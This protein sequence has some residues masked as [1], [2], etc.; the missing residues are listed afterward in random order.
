MRYLPAK[1]QMS[2]KQWISPLLALPPIYITLNGKP[3]LAKIY[4]AISEKH[5]WIFP[6]F[7]T[8]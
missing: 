4:H 6:S 7:H 1:A 3:N 8:T 5:M 2:L